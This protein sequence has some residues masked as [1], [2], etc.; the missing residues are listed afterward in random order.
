VT[1]PPGIPAERLATLRAAF[2]ALATDPDFL[3]DAEKSGME[4]APLPGDAVD[5]VIALIA[6]TPAELAERLTKAI[7]PPG[8]T[9]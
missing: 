9:R 2:A 4:A 8:Q 1:A 3:A 7:A 5:K 6:G